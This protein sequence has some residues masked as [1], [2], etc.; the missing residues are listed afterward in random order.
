M[1]ANLSQLIRLEQEAVDEETKGDRLRELA[2]ISTELARLVANNPS[3]PP[4][5]LQELSTNS[6][7]TTYENYQA[8]CKAIAQNLN[9]PPDLLRTLFA[10]F[11]LQVLNNPV[12][13]LLLLE[14]P[15]FLNTLYQAKP[16]AFYE[17]GLPFFFL[18]WATHHQNQEICAAVADS[19]ETPQCFLEQ[20]AQ[21]K[22][23][24]VRCTVAKNYN[25]PRH[26]LEQ[27]AKDS[28]KYV[29]L[30]VAENPYTPRSLTLSLLEQL[31]QAQEIDIR[32]TVAENY[33]TPERTLEQLAKDSNTG[34]RLAAADN[35]KTSKSSLQQLVQDKDHFICL[36]AAKNLVRLLEE[37]EF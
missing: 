15:N 14:N 22:E 33:N 8:I 11:P 18:K 30:A 21:D 24:D 25:S 32:C 2:K 17:S 7:A 12:I 23:V 5:L 4:E 37:S 10:E 29:R 20:L 35:P 1:E 16:W 26:T 6:D 19:P 28:D 36:A 13:D 3:A 9:T 27:L 34:V 31:A